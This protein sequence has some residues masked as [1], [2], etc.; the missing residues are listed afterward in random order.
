VVGHW[1]SVVLGVGEQPA[2]PLLEL[3]DPLELLPLVMVVPKPPVPLELLVPETP[4]NPPLPEVSPTESGPRMLVQ[5]VGA[6]DII[7]ATSRVA[8][9]WCFIRTSPAR[10][11]HPGRPRA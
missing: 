1:H 9:K 8:S 2:V 5:A 3:V 7:A 6:S 11:A 10:R 4:P